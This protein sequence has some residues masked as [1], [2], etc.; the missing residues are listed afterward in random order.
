[1]ISRLLIVC[2]YTQGMDLDKLL[3]AP[4]VRFN[5]RQRRGHFC[6]LVSEGNSCKRHVMPATVEIPVPD[7]L[8]LHSKDLAS[9][10]LRS[11]FLLAMKF[12][13]L[14]ELSSG[15]AAEMCGLSRVGFLFEA[16]KLGVPVAELSD[17]E[18]S[19]EFA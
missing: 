5:L 13:E 10:Q 2:N 18:L 1:M 6:E 7:S 9:L 16:G 4:F 12:F 11:R 17:D 3:I 15:Q 19:E 14:G 8:L